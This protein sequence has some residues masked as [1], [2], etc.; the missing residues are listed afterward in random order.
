MHGVARLLPMNFS[1]HF[2]SA[3][4]DY[5]RSRP[6]YPEALYEHLASLAPSDDCALDCATG[7]GQA[8]LGLAR[9]FE[10]VIAVD[11]SAS[12][13]EHALK[14]PRV[15]YQQRLAEDT[16]VP[17][18]SCDIVTVAAGAHW[19]DLKRFYAEVQRVL[20]PGGVIAVWTYNGWPQIG[21]EIERAIAQFRDETPQLTWPPGFEHVRSGYRSLPFPFESLPAP[22]FKAEMRWD[23]DGL[24]GHLRSWSAV[25]A[26]TKKLGRDPVEP[27]RARLQEAWGDP[28]EVRWVRWPL[29]M[30]LGRVG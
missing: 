20:R 17:P 7:S 23:L 1:D 27:H 15:E 24:L 8:A 14:H 18:A 11:G 13:L 21:P 16:G 29:H 25:Q 30:R 19:L 28:Q 9:V 4:Q 3:P 6:S 2:S 22:A 26:L 5:L 10:R 12:Q